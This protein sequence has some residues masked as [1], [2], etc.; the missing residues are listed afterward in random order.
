MATVADSMTSGLAGRGRL[1]LDRSSGFF[2][3]QRRKGA[4]T[5]SVLCS[6]DVVYRNER[7]TDASYHC[8]EFAVA[9][10]A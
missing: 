8:V 2:S 9:D 7:Q 10:N 3:T 5:L 4:K 6:Y 1:R